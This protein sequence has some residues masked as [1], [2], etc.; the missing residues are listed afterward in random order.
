M[1]ATVC[2]QSGATLEHLVAQ[3]ARVQH[4]SVVADDR[5]LVERLVVR[6]IVMDLFVTAQRRLDAER[7][8]ALSAHVRQFAGV[9]EHVQEERSLRPS[10]PTAQR[11]SER[12][13][14]RVK[15]LVED[16]RVAAVELFAARSASVPDSRTAVNDSPCIGLPPS[17]FDTVVHS[18]VNDQRRQ[19]AEPFRALAARVL[20]SN[21]VGSGPR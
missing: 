8:A 10:F 11:T 21:V 2:E 5:R 15:P 1:D 4:L 12:F 18:T 16:Q 7:L 3:R 9:D 17:W 6:R 19:Q 20:P 13:L 14:A